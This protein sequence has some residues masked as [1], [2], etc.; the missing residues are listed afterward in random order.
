MIPTTIPSTAP[1]TDLPYTS[2][3]I[4]TDSFDSDTP[5][6]PPSQDPYKVTIAR[7]KSRVAPILVGRPYHY[8]SSNSHSDTS[9]YSSSRHS[10]SGYS[11]SDSLRDLPTATSA[12][13]SR[14]RCRSPTSSIPVVSPVSSE[15]GYVPYVPREV[16]LGV[17]VEDSYEPYTEP[18]VDS[19]IQA[20]INT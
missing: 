1:T 11:I 9:S 18:D 13:P 8:S 17:Y 16:S 2:P 3:F 5:D 15:D 19:D 4:E 14:K 10:S 20:D 6:T 12:R 7:W